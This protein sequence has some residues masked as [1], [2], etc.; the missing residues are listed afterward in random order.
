LESTTAKDA[1]VVVSQ[2]TDPGMSAT[3]PS[4]PESNKSPIFCAIL[5]NT[6]YETV[7]NNNP[8]RNTN[9]QRKD[10]PVYNYLND[11]TT[12]WAMIT[13]NFYVKINVGFAPIV[14]R[15]F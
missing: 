12:V 3:Q 9:A 6:P 1:Y 8:F 5:E 11:I 10:L 7:Y 4:D 13:L 2:A 15:I 14:S